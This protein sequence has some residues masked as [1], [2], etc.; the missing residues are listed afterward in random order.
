MSFLL[1]SRVLR[2]DPRGAGTRT[3][4]LATLLFALY[5]FWF[6]LGWRRARR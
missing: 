2:L 5:P 3:H 1:N 6:W 4:A